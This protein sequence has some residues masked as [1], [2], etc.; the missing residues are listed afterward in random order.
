MV[1][2]RL[3]RNKTFWLNETIFSCFRFDNL[4]TIR[5][6][7][8]IKLLGDCY[9]AVS[10]L[11]ETRTDHAV[12]CVEMGLDMIDAI[13][14]VGPAYSM[15][16]IIT[17]S[18]HFNYYPFPRSVRESTNVNVNMRVGIHSGRVLCGVLGLR[19]WQFDVWSNDVTLA[20]HM[21][22]GGVPG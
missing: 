1:F 17:F 4:A 10:G 15:P 19:K 7:L 16:K 18:C 6:C 3:I 2:V 14:L 22:A 5:H 11:P 8:R 12:C 21:E 20:N 13:K 9:Y